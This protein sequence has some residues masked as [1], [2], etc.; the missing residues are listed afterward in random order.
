MKKDLIKMIKEYQNYLLVAIGVTMLLVGG[1]YG[2][3]YYK[4]SREERAY[5]AMVTAFEYFD[6]PIK[7]GEAKEK[8]LSFLGKKEFSSANEKWEKVALVFKKAYEDHG[9]SGIAPFF[10]AFQVEA[11]IN[12]GNIPEAIKLLREVIRLLTNKESKDYY[13]S[14]LA[15][16]LTDTK[17]DKNIQEG[18]AMLK[19]IALDDESV[20]HDL[21]LFHLGNYYW[22]HKQFTEARNY[23]NQLV[24]KY[25][26][27]EKYASPWV[28][29]A[30]SRLRL[31]DSD[32]E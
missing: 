32:A 15:L 8:D 1:T 19:K 28:S 26:K 9:N 22:C 4:V 23:W 11:L 5:R 16:L 7:S 18:L 6:A 29:A 17:N 10:L 27:D 3:S 24:L 20:A 12:L 30:M 14:K 25:G 21:S 2:Y 31:I 13:Q